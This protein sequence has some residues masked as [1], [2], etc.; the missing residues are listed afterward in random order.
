MLYAPEA[1]EPL[2]ETP[3][4]P[5]GVSELVREIAADADAAFREDALW[6][7]HE[8]E[9]WQTPLP[10]QGLYA[11]AAGV[12]WALA[13]LRDRGRAEPRLDLARAAR[14]T[15]EAWR[16][17]PSL[18]RIDLPQ[19]AEAS[20]LDGEAGILTVLLR[21]E[22][23]DKLADRL[24]ELVRANANNAADEVMWG[25][26]GTM[27]AAGSLREA[28]GDERW[29]A[30]WRESAS[31]LLARRDH[32]GLWTQHLHGETS[33]GL[34]PVHGAVGNVLSLLQGGEL[35]TAE[36]RRIL[37]DETAA[38]LRRTAVVEDGLANWPSTEDRPLLASDGQIRVQWDVGAPGIVASTASY[39]DEDLL[40]AGAELAWRAGPHGDEKGAGLCHGTAGNGYALLKAFER[41]QDERWLER[42]RRFAVHAL[43][44]ATRA[45][46]E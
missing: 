23:N 5:S 45:H 15:L 30:V 41:T 24:L 42:A 13:T 21:L 3:W 33:R 40:L 27:L 14:L 35:L 1:F 31:A 46:E 28:T 26:P 29:A 16:R 19:P 12:I 43:E 9:A 34:G 36:E 6:P 32:D 4:D 18:M 37:E 11:G 2:T 20:L 38:L 10:L 44:Q 39:L 7:A 25:A 17:E 22:P 8:W